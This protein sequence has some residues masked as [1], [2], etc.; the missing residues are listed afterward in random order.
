MLPGVPLPI[1]DVKLPAGCVV[2][3]V[4]KVVVVLRLVE[5]DVLVAR[6]VVL[7]V[8]LLV[9]LLVENVVVNVV[10]NVVVVSALVPAVV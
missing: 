5:R 7:L 3:E 1:Q 4:L 2:R 9:V 10:S 6:L 8:E